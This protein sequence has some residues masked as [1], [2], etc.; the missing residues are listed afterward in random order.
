MGR[1]TRRGDFYQIDIRYAEGG[2]ENYICNGVEKWNY[3]AFGDN[4]SLIYRRLE[5]VKNKLVKLAPNL[6]LEDY[7]QIPNVMLEPMV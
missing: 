6:K 5:L 3:W 1:I 4:L 7:D 2:A